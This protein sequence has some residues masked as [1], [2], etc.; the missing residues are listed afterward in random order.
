M[1]KK[2]T[3]Q[4]AFFNQRVLIGLFVFIAGVFLAMFATSAIERTHRGEA[5]PFAG[6]GLR[7]GAQA[8]VSAPDF[9]GQFSGGAPSG[10]TI[11]LEQVASGLTSPVTVTNAGDGS[12]RIFIVQQTGQIRILSGGTLL[13]TPFLDISA[14]VS[15]CGEQGLL[16]L[17]FHPDYATNGFF[18]VDYTNVAGDTVVARY[19]VSATDP[20]VADPDSAQTVLT[21]DQPF[22]NHNGGQLAFGPDG[23]LYIALGD[24]GSAGDP[25][26]NGQ[27]LETWLGKLLRVDVNGDDFPDDPNRNYAVPPNNPFVANDGLD[28]IWAYGLRNPWRCTFDRATGA[29]FIADV[30]QSAWEEINFQPAASGGGE[31]YGWNVL[32]GMHCF[33]DVPPG[34]CNAFLNGGS[35]LPILEYDHSLGCSVTGGYRYRGQL[36]P[37]LDGI[38]FYGDLCSGRVWGATRHGDGTWVSEELLISGFT[39][40]TFGEDEAAELYIASYSGGALYRIVGGPTPTPTPTATPTPTPTATPSPTPT[41][42]PITLSASGRKVGGINTVRLSWSGATS[43]NIDVYRN[44]VPPIATVPNTGTYTDSTGDTGRARYTYRVCEAGTSTCSNDA[45]VT[46]QE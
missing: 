12:G 42:G 45:R 27:N 33:N 16:G 34:I 30:G 11:Q 23:Y 32:E 5:N 44:G 10:T 6:G 46:F 19:E 7:P 8:E 15:C 18:Y 13:P 2:S 39:I 40:S 17:A 35:T 28:E 31:N 20:N 4:S 9:T 25:Q 14:L 21:Q 3:F 41:P 38:Y 36:Y 22:A 1:K 37:Q 26:G 24:G 29:L 43:T